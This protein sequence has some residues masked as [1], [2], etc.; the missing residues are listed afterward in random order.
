MSLVTW[1]RVGGRR[2]GNISK[3]HRAI[4]DGAGEKLIQHPP[5]ARIGVSPVLV[6]AQIQYL[7]RTNI[8]K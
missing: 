2:K 5:S 1:P 6:S 4:R 3:G 7:P 8:R